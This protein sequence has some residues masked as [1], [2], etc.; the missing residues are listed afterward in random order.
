M[1]EGWLQTQEMT[2][3]GRKMRYKC[4]QEWGAGVGPPSA[5][6]LSC[7]HWRKAPG[8]A[9]LETARRELRLR[10]LAL[11]CQGASPRTALFSPQGWAE[12]EGWRRWILGLLSASWWRGCSMRTGAGTLMTGRA[13]MTWSRPHSLDAGQREPAFRIQTSWSLGAQ[14]RRFWKVSSLLSP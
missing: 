6:T 7:Q 3:F 4:R 10:K 2:D 5:A 12:E 14:P 1:W 13:P 11:C 8:F 9:T